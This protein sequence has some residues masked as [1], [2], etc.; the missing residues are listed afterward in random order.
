MKTANDTTEPITDAPLE[1]EVESVEQQV[2][3][4]KDWEQNNR[5]I[6]KAVI[7]YWQTNKSYPTQAEIASLS[8]LSPRTV[9]THMKEL[10]QSQVLDDAAKQFAV[11][12]PEFLM[13]VLNSSL[14]GSSK[15]QELF[16]KLVLKWVPPATLDLTGEIGIKDGISKLIEKARQTNAEH[17]KANGTAAAPITDGDTASVTTGESSDRSPASDTQ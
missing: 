7:D 15:S 17:A 13:A 5:K 10:D 14:R 9:F 1:G 4:R 2:E 3:R 11:H 8:G 12:A 16:A 6:S